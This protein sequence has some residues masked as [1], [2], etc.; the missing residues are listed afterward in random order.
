MSLPAAVVSGSYRSASSVIGAIEAYRR[1]QT[2][3]SDFVS[4]SLSSSSGPS[5]AT[6]PENAFQENDDLD[7]FDD[8]EDAPSIRERTRSSGEHPFLA[9]IQWDDDLTPAP[10]SEGRQ[11]DFRPAARAPWNIP[12][13]FEDEDDLPTPRAGPGERTP[14]MARSSS[15]RTVVPNYR[16]PAQV[17]QSIPEHSALQR[18]ASHLS[19]RSKS[20]WRERKPSH[21]GQSTF[22]QTLL[23]AV[24]VLFGI[25]ML[26]EPMAF[27]YA[28]WIWGT[29][30]II[31][32]GYISCYTAKILARI[33]LGD[34]TI[35]SYADIGRKAFGPRSMPLISAIFGLELFTVSVALVTLYADSLH[36]VLPEYSSD[37]YKLIGLAIMIPAVLM[38]LS[39]LSFASI[40]GIFSL[41]AIICI[42]I[43]DGFTKFDSP[44]SLWNPA[45]T[46]LGIDNFK[47][48]GVAFGLFM[49]GFSGHAVIPTLARDMQD[50]SRFD[51][52]INWAF[53]VA[54]GIYGLLGVVGYIMFGNAVS[55][56]FSQDLMRYNTHPALNTIALWGLVITPL[57]K[58]ALTAR[59]L[60]V[61]IEMFFGLESGAADPHDP[62]GSPISPSSGH[63]SK[64]KELLITAERIAL[65]LLSVAVSI[66][67]PEFASVMAVL[68]STFSFLLCIIGPVCAKVA[69]AGGARQCGFWDAI[70]LAVS[71]A[72]AVWGT[73]CAFESA[74]PVL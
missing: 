7:P 62:H 71:T 61:T 20:S 17:E 57:S 2:Q 32:Y 34:N 3:H 37:I 41:V 4:G 9:N 19:T 45:A 35:R 49:A 24:A 47:E 33:V 55:D 43:F 16:T 21:G 58:Y 14:L 66:L 63:S 38:P 68:G 22:A 54:T 6:D 31:G 30:L 10:T 26:S 72:M 25:G 64:T 70:L 48:L 12:P 65:T 1:T 42:I 28:G 52:M 74:N 73:I 13:A 29:I 36:A 5:A 18:R 51:E 56:E 67:I 8:D 23:N 39:V 50:P 46:S 53:V 11:Y 59:P 27:S 44:G 69:L 60:N 40:V 15:S